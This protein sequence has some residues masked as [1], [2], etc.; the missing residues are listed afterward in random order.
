ML[1]T[2]ADCVG[3]G[4]EGLEYTSKAGKKYNFR[5]FTI[6]DAGS[7]EKWLEGR[8][9]QAVEAAKG[10]MDPGDYGQALAS[11]SADVATGRF[12]FGGPEANRAMRTLPGMCKLMSLMAGITFQEAKD[13]FATEGEALGKALES[14]INRSMPQGPEGNAPKEAEAPG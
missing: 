2:V 7:F 4:A 9:F 6:N 10:T 5:A 13:L 3:V 12:S 8:A 11:I 1:R 14:Q